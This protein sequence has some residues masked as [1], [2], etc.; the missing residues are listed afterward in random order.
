MILVISLGRPRLFL[1]L[2]MAGCRGLVDVDLSGY[3]ECQAGERAA[4][5][6]SR[7]ILDAL[8]RRHQALDLCKDA[9]Q[10]ALVTS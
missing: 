3:W 7:T 4:R 8:L 1:A 9:F 5:G 10:E 2:G 6:V